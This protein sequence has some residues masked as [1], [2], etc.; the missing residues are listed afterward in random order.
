MN[1]NKTILSKEE[2]EGSEADR[3]RLSGR[4]EGLHSEKLS[5][6]LA[7]HSLLL[8]TT[9]VNFWEYMFPLYNYAGFLEMHHI[10]SFSFKSMSLCRFRL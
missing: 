10:I 1:D 6:R 2:E 5:H 7:L 3:E 9:T 4:A 8:S